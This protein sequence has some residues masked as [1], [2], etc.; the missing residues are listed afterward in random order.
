MKVN[1]Y[2]F[3]ASVFRGQGQD[4]EQWHTNTVGHIN[5]EH[6]L[7]P[8]KREAMVELAR[9]GAG[10]V[11]AVNGPPGTGKTTL[12]QSV[13]AQLWIDAAL[14]ESECPLIVV[15]STNVKAVE[16]VLDSFAKICAETGHK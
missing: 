14:K 8:S 4:A 12:L 3:M 1:S 9:L 16:N 11:L 2:T 10:Q 5:R 13:V 6:P 7:S 15:T